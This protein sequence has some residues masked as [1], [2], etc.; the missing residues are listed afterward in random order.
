[1]LPV[2]G[3]VES[4]RSWREE[5]GKYS[6]NDIKGHLCLSVLSTIIQVKTV[7]VVAFKEESEHQELHIILDVHPRS[8]ERGQH[9]SQELL[10]LNFIQTVEQLPRIWWQGGIS[11][12]ELLS[13]IL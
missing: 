10:I 9:L 12:L 7:H 8:L 3:M 6:Q 5:R 4:Q 1:M 2:S 11:A 13:S